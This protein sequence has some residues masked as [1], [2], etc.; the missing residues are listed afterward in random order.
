MAPFSIHCSPSLQIPFNNISNRSFAVENYEEK[1]EIWALAEKELL[2]MPHSD[3]LRRL[4]LN[5]GDFEARLRAVSWIL[6]VQKFHSFR[7]ETA[8]LAVNYLDRFMACTEIEQAKRGWA[9]QLASVASLSLAAKMEENSVPLLINLQVEGAEYIFEARTVQRMELILLGALKWRMSTVTP[10]SYICHG[11]HIL[12]LQ[13]Q[14]IRNL[15][16]RCN[17]A[18]LCI[19]KDIRVLN[20]R[21]SVVAAAIMLCTMRKAQILN[22]VECERRLLSGLKVDK[23]IV[24]ECYKLVLESLGKLISSWKRRV[25]TS[26]SL[27]QGSPHGVMDASFSC[28][29]DNSSANYAPKDP[30]FEPSA[31]KKRRIGEYFPTN[32]SVEKVY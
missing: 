11:T 15:T 14:Q 21:P 28:N 23:G 17:E 6:K 29:S 9:M 16:L 19:V 25:C 22:S 24:E 31:S 13:K 10:L 1:A 3:Y 2:Y 5:N 18:A 32:K 7:A 27:Q 12:G 4:A 20:F 8:L 26:S 30:S